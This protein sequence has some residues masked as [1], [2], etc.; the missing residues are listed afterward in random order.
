MQHILL[1]EDEDSLRETLADLLTLEG[2]RVT[3][4]AS[5]AEGLRLVEEQP[6]ELILCDIMMPGMDGYA[7]LRK[8][9]LEERTAL[10]P[11]IFLTAKADP[12]QVREGMELGADDYLCKP[13][14]KAELLAAIRTRLWKH[15]QQR[16]RI[17]HEV[18]AARQDV[19]RKLP[20]ELLTPLTG[21]LS[22]SQLLESADR[23]LSVSAIRELGRVTRLAAQRLHRMIR[24][25]LLYAELQAASHQPEAQARLRGTSHI[26]AT[27]L[28]SALAEH[29]A[30]QYSRSEDLR[31]VLDEV[32]AIMDLTHFSEL[33]AH[34]VDN[35]L[36]FSATGSL[37]HVSLE[38]L[39][40][41]GCELTVRDEGRGITPEQ[42]Q[43]AG[44]FHQF[45]SDV[46]AQPG[47][48]LGLALVDQI[49]TLY[50]GRLDLKGEPG[51]GTE[52][53]VYLPH[54]RRGIEGAGA[55]APEL[56]RR[57]AWALGNP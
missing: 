25:F 27:S 34:L 12:P 57:V 54:A 38:V 26:P 51:K 29:L 5:G 9:Q 50:G 55:L 46:W 49:T 14:S 56:Q 53:T 32:E 19:V 43:Q 3:M 48:G 52:A 31:L 45:A 36:K 41:G 24:R 11:F 42:V 21:L 7:V 18:E 4:A 40:G 10:I 39:P 44:A 20:L 2:F 22:A 28:T 37:V 13:V 6:P 8:L 16:E 1:I 23:T 47:T 15:R 33:V 30:R 35:A 17:E